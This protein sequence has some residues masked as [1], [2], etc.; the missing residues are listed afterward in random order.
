MA[1]GMV[2]ERQR[3]FAGGLGAVVGL[4]LAVAACASTPGPEEPRINPTS[5][6]SLALLEGSNTRGED[7]SGSGSGASC[8]EVSDEARREAREMGAGEEAS[9]EH[10]EEIREVLNDGHFLTECDVP[11]ASAVEL[12]VAVADGV[13][14]GVTVWLKPGSQEAITCVADKIRELSFPQHELVSIARTNFDPN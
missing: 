1:T 6:P 13:A 11:S 7:L 2:D 8:E 5:V 3:A 12:C 10:G 9:E 4:G 14:K